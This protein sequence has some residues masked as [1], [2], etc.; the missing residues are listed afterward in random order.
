MMTSAV[1]PHCIISMLF[2]IGW[3]ALR[4]DDCTTVNANLNEIALQGRLYNLIRHSDPYH[5]VA[6]IYR[7]CMLNDPPLYAS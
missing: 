7:L 1:Q 5:I 3:D 4:S 6:V 2:I